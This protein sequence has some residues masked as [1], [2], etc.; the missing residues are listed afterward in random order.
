[1]STPIAIHQTLGVSHHPRSR[2]TFN[3]V[4]CGAS[5]S[6]DTSLASATREQE[7]RKLSYGRW[8]EKEER[9]R[10]WN[11]DRHRVAAI[12]TRRLAKLEREYQREVWA[13]GAGLAQ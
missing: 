3:M 12:R 6:R 13:D 11:E 8:L 1:M 7:R 5:S 4:F 10:R 9:S 2:S